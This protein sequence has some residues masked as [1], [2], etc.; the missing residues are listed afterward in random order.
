MAADQIRFEDGAAYEKWMGIWSQL[1]GTIFLDWLAPR[2]GIRWLDIGCGNGAFTELL[3]DG[4]LRPES[5]ASIR[6]RRS[7]PLRATAG[8]A[9]CEFQQGDAMALP[10]ATNASTRLSWRW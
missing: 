8:G 7:S 6:P 1:A 10:F 2:P 4:A 3:V 5:K 9:G